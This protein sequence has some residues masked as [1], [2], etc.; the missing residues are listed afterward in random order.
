MKLFLFLLGA[1]A[2]PVI[3]RLSLINIVSGSSQGDNDRHETTSTKPV[4][5]H[6]MIANTLPYSR[7]D[8]ERDFTLASSKGIDAFALN[9]GPDSWHAARVDEAFSTLHSL[10]LPFYL[11]FSFDMAVL[12][13][14][15]P[16]DA[17]TLRN[18]IS[19]YGSHPNYLLHGRYPLVSTFAGEYCRF[20]Q[21]SLN[22]AWQYAIKNG[23]RPNIFVP[24][25]FTK[26]SDL[27]SL[28]VM[29]GYFS[30]NSGWP[31]GNYDID[32]NSD[33][34]FIRNLDGRL[35]MAP[36]SPWFFTHYGP[37][38]FNKNWIYRSDDWLFAK[39]WELIV[40]NRAY[41]DMVEAITWNDYGESSY[42]G[43]IHGTQPFSQSW[44]NGFDHRVW[45]DIQQYHIEAFKYGAYQDVT[46]DRVYLWG[47][48]YPKVASAPDSVGRPNNWDWAEDS[49][50]AMAFLIE[51]SHLTLSCGR[52][53]QVFSAPAG[54]SKM[55]LPFSETCNVKA[56]VKRD[57]KTIISCEP[58]GFR[59]NTNPPSYNFNAFVAACP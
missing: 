1:L 33:S 10:D 44:V 3:A 42:L 49:L 45:L 29:D 46:E 58:P 48:L 20:G 5:A 6:F 54:V 32:F 17:N 9:I 35:Y 22:E 18:Y 41:V 52:T 57:D 13:C 36:V 4:F 15:S 11:F 31:M 40:D 28:P 37:N 47:R 24:A 53:S 14:N 21:G 50:W 39:R 8:W 59:F 12:P 19:K 51:D 16:G 7:D 23:V 55:K 27:S 34:N 38:T 2:L 56:V 26:A 43:E 30:W 25:F